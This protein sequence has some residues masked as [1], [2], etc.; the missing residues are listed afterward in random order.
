MY[1]YICKYIYIIYAYIY[2]TKIVTVILS[3]GFFNLCGAD[4]VIYMMS[5]FSTIATDTQVPCG[6]RL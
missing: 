3:K 6:A 5:R 1:I 4:T 2:V